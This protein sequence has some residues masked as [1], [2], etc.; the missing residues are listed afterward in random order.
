MNDL[1]RRYLRLLRAYPAEYRRARGAEIVGTYLDLAATG[2]RWPSPADAADLVRGGVRQRLRATGAADLIP[3]VRLAAVLALLTGTA[4][5]AVWSVLE[6]RPPA[7]YW[8]VPALGPVA[9]LGAGVWVAWLLPALALAVD[10]ARWARRAIGLALLL[11]VAVVPV[12]EL[13]GL[14]RPPLFTLLP[15]AALGLVA[16]ALPDRLSLPV[17]LAMP[18]TAVGA[19]A[20]TELLYARED[21]YY[22][23]WT[24]IEIILGMGRSLLAVT[25]LL[26][27]GLLVVGDRRGG[28]AA[29]T[30]LT[31]IG[32]LLLQDLVRSGAAYLPVGRNAAFSGLALAATTVTLLGTAALGAAVALSARA[33]RRT[34]PS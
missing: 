18:L 1:E 9:T 10:S 11:T 30:L 13:A 20:A 22:Y 15:Q 16:L 21:H 24:S 23:G 5:A 33:G 29:L 12:A 28:W 34:I 31:P 4:L 26:A 6:L 14:P 3:G 25:L 7:P 17:R 19:A 27:I 8:G 2:R 32:L